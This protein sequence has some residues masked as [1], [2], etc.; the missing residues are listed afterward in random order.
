M[1]SSEKT[2]NIKMAIDYVRDILA[3]E[4]TINGI[5]IDGGRVFIWNQKFRI[6]NDDGA[7]V[8]L[9]YAGSPVMISNRVSQVSTLGGLKDVQDMN[10]NERIIVSMFSR[11]MDALRNFPM[12]AFSLRGTY[13]QQTMEENSFHIAR[14]SGVEELS[15]LEATGMLYRFDMTVSVNSWYQVEKSID[16]YSSFQVQA[17]TEAVTVTFDPTTDPLS[18]IT[19]V[20]PS[21]SRVVTTIDSPIVLSY[22][23]EL[24]FGPKDQDGSWRMVRSGTD[25]SMQR[26]ENGVWVEKS[27]AT[28]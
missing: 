19:E 4:I 17:M 24:Y 22:V 6:P 7:F 25:F 15:D 3:H 5:P 8:L 14:V 1:L 2:G 28:P 12:M 16:F 13:A 23:T 11:N 20:T 9:R 18:M 26:R 27:A 21:G 10:L